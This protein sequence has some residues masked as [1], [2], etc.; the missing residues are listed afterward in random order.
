M[1]HFCHACIWTLMTM[2]RWSYQRM[3]VS[4]IYASCEVLLV[5]RL[6]WFEGDT[7]G[8]RFNAA[9]VHFKSWCRRMK[10]VTSILQFDL[11]KTFGAKSYWSK[12][13][14]M[15]IASDVMLLGSDEAERQA[16]SAWK[17]I[18]HSDCGKVASVVDGDRATQRSPCRA[19]TL[20][21]CKGV[22]CAMH[23]ALRPLNLT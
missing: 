5:G 7:I 23:L 10:V 6:A 18:R 13:P 12:S 14:F 21:S 1:I 4:C 9:Y 17:G 3:H 22:C 15:T 11:K 20:Q 8:Q 19:L 2:I 16:S